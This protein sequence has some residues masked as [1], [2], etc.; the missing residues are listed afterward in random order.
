MQQVMQKL[1]FIGLGEMDSPIAE[2]LLAAG[3]PVIGHRKC[4]RVEKLFSGQTGY[5]LRDALK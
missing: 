4:D 2:K 3:C 1:S 5:T